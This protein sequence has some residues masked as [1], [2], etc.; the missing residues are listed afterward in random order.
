MELCPNLCEALG[1]IPW[2]TENKTS[3]LRMKFQFSQ[4]MCYAS[5]DMQ[6]DLI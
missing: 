2:K 6:T 4:S 1:S 5:Y 3:E